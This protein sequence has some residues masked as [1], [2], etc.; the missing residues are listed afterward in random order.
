MPRGK[1][2]PGKEYRS[3]CTSCGWRG[4]SAAL[5]FDFEEYYKKKIE[6]IK[7]S[8]KIDSSKIQSTIDFIKKH[9][10]ELDRFISV[11]TLINDGHIGNLHDNND[12]IE[13]DIEFGQTLIDKWSEKIASGLKKDGK[14]S[15]D[16]VGQSLKLFKYCMGQSDNI[17]LTKSKVNPHVIN[18]INI[19]LSSNNSVELSRRYCPE[20]HRQVS[21][22]SGLYKEIV[23]SL[24]GGPRASKTT[25]LLSTVYSLR[26]PEIK[27][28]GFSAILEPDNELRKAWNQIFIQLNAYQN[29][30]RPD[31]TKVDKD[32]AIKF[33]FLLTLGD[34]RSVLISFV[35]IAGEF[36]V[37]A[38]QRVDDLT[39]E[40][41]DRYRRI[42]NNTD[43]LWICVDKK[44]LELT[45]RLPP[46]IDDKTKKEFQ[47]YGYFDETETVGTAKNN[48]TNIA[49]FDKS[50]PLPS[51]EMILAL[52]H[53]GTWL[54]NID[55]A[56][57][58]W[59][60]ID[61]D[62]KK[63]SPFFF[64]DMAYYE[65]NSI[66]TGKNG[67][68]PILLPERMLQIERFVKNRMNDINKRVAENVKKLFK[69]KIGVFATSNYG[70]APADNG[71]Q[72]ADRTIAPLHAL[73]P[74]V[75][76]LAMAGVLEY[77]KE[78]HFGG[79]KLLTAKVDVDKKNFCV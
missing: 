50:A 72:D 8:G 19:R 44:I 36:I 15:D 39:G 27:E 29:N 21:S 4:D 26:Q 32:A 45:D 5:T 43:Y 23:I 74:I 20:C 13:G 77:Q 54:R 6:T 25:T 22:F 31:P 1:T 52:T 65:K 37:A 2:K 57:V 33:S 49:D 30:D 64:D 18:T 38:A 10:N 63:Q 11:E 41:F 51:T 34:E 35:D 67:S 69:N 42:Y 12:F 59:G 24:F 48:N 73:H 55:G 7:F 56:A 14:L 78:N 79:V 53:V 68:D 66:I 61:L 16:E 17:I 28:Q 76:T 71:S 9:L 60:K 62:G 3:F 46:N 47:R 40:L 70:H 75:W 58:I